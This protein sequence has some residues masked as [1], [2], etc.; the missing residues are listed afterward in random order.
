MAGGKP[1]RPKSPDSIT[2]RTPQ[3]ATYLTPESFPVVEEMAEQLG[4]SRAEVVRQLVDQGLTALRAAKLA[5]DAGAGP[6]EVERSVV[7]AI[8]QTNIK[9]DEV[10]MLHLLDLIEDY[11]QTVERRRPWDAVRLALGAA[12]AL[13]GRGDALAA[14]LREQGQADHRE[15]DLVTNG[16][17]S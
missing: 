10:V 9:I 11:L 17:A 6:T 14:R 3:I 4:L 8:R 2:G 7:E 16:K 12:T 15:D 13:Q 1:G 5:E